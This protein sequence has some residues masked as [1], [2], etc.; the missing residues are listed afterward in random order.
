MTKSGIGLT[1]HDDQFREDPQPIYDGLRGES[2]AFRD[3]DYGS[4]FLTRYDDARKVLR[5]KDYG[6][7]AR[8]SLPDSYMRR[9]AG[10]GVSEGRGKTAYEPPLVLLD[11]PGHRRIRALMSKAF[12][13]H[14]IEQMRGRIESITAE[15]LDRLAPGSEIDFIGDFAGP[16]PTRVI[17]EMMG[18]PAVHCA[19]LKRWSDDILRGYDPERDEA[20]QERLRAAYIA[21]SALFRHAVDER[22]RTG[23]T[24]LICAMVRAQEMDDRLTD[25]EIISLCTQLLVAGN[26]TTTDLLGNGLHALMAHPRQLARLCAQPALIE[27]AVE[28]ILRYDCP[29]TETARIAYAEDRGG[30][31]PVHRGA[32]LT[33]SL[34][35]ANHD[36]ALCAE[37]HRFDIEREDVPHLAFGSGIHVCLG[38]PLARLEGCVAILAFV[39]RFP[40]VRLGSTPPRRRHLPFFRGFESLPVRI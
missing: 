21:M 29:L 25:L 33:V 15:M 35:A 31:C 26:V 32:T 24:D 40:G 16:L 1:A 13:P 18:I 7:D 2:P 17:A 36:P 6:V 12:N 3:A 14:S 4:L 8:K 19:D 9:V 39:Q 23:G 38:A 28:E 27:R 11:D 34:A 37:P 30:S 20:A 22:R 5:S 10:T